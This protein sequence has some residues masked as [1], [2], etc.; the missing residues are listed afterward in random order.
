MSRVKW[1]GLVFYKNLIF[2]NKSFNSFKNRIKIVPRFLA[3]NPY[4]VGKNFLVHNGKYLVK[5][6]INSNMIGY[7]FGI[8]VFTKSLII[9]K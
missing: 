9:K 3:I 5:L 4:F 6:K 7:K 2:K 1:K 8:F